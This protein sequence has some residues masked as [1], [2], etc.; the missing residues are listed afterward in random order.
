MNDDPELQALTKHLDAN[1]KIA[2]ALGIAPPVET[3]LVPVKP[4]IDRPVAS[5]SQ[6]END[7]EYARTNIYDIIEQGAS[8]VAEAQNLARESAHPRAFEVLAQLLKVQSDNVDKLLKL[9]QD[10]QKL[11][12]ATTSGTSN[13]PVNIEKAVFVGTTAQLLDMIRSETPVNAIDVDV[14]EEND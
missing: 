12:A 8:A 11:N 4:R 6:I 10:K 13:M 2:V 1:S 3:P 9:H 14:E 7:A 5:N